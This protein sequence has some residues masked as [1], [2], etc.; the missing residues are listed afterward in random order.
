MWYERSWQG[1]QRPSPGEQAERSAARSRPVNAGWGDG[2]ARPAAV[3]STATAAP[4]LLA[5]PALPSQSQHL[6]L[7]C[8]E[9][10]PQ[11]NRAP[12]RATIRGHRGNSSRQDYRCDVFLCIY[13]WLVAVPAGPPASKRPALQTRAS[14]DKPGPCATPSTPRCCQIRPFSSF[15]AGI[16]WLHRNNLEI[17]FMGTELHFIAS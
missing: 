4:R 14:A 1:R 8:H 13:T 9:Q 6:G 16:T 3:T 7:V 12:Y 10:P 15:K 17:T 11:I 5:S 2:K